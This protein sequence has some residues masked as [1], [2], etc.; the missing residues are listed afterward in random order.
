[1]GDLAVP[2][3]TFAVWIRCTGWFLCCLRTSGGQVSYLFGNDRE[4]LTMLSCPGCFN[5]GV[6]SEDIGLEGYI[7][8]Y[9]DDFGDIG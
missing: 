6:Q 8:D 5:S 4:A 7:V 9:L 2:L 1:M 3:S